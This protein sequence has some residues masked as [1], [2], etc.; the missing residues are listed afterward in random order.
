SHPAVAF[1]L[2]EPVLPARLR[3]VR[4]FNSGVILVTSNRLLDLAPD[5]PASLYVQMLRTHSAAQLWSWHLQAEGLFAD[6][7]SPSPPEHERI[8]RS[9]GDFLPGRAGAPSLQAD[10]GGPK[11]RDPMEV[12]ME[13]VV[14]FSWRHRARRLWLLRLNPFREYWRLYA[15]RGLS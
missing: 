1:L 9:P 7:A 10:V 5:P 2:F 3:I 4:R 11:G 15:L 13:I 6:E 14:R 8:T 12:F